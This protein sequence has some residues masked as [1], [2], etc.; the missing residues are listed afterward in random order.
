MKRFL[1]PF[2]LMA[3]LSANA[4][5]F[6]GTYAG[7]SIH[8]GHIDS[9]DFD[10]GGETI[11][12]WKPRDP[13]FGIGA[14][15]GHRFYL[16]DT[17]GVAIETEYLRFKSFDVDGTAPLPMKNFFISS[18]LTLNMHGFGANIKP[19]FYIGHSKFSINPMVGAMHWRGKVTAEPNMF[20]H[21]EHVDKQHEWGVSYGLEVQ[22]HAD[23][24]MS[25]AVG[26]RQ[27]KTKFDGDDY[28]MDIDIT[29]LYA[30]M[31]YYF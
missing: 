30:N 12:D 2:I 16:T 4:S 7:L 21:N 3:S 28:D 15:L 9:V 27:F 5:V 17:I 29:S 10:D 22:Y 6:D 31:N 24:S 8:Q 11:M 23:N 1:L 19:Q 26:A 18:P 25:F 20:D 14:V 13:E